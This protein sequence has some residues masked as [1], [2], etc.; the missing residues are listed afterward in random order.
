MSKIFNFNNVSTTGNSLEFFSDNDTFPRIGL[1]FGNSISRRGISSLKKSSKPNTKGHPGTGGQSVGRGVEPSI[2]FFRSI[3]NSFNPSLKSID[4]KKWNYGSDPN[5]IHPAGFTPPH[6][7]LKTKDGELSETWQPFKQFGVKEEHEIT[8]GNLPYTNPASGY[9][10]PRRLKERQELVGTIDLGT[11]NFTFGLNKNTEELTIEQKFDRISDSGFESYAGLQT[12]KDKLPLSSFTNTIL[13]NEDPTILGF[14]IEIDEV[15]SPLFNGAVDDFINKYG[16][17]QEIGGR[18]GIYSEFIAQFKKFFKTNASQE[19][20]DVVKNYYITKL[21]GLDKVGHVKSA[22]TSGDSGENL[23]TNFPTDKIEISIKE[24][25]EQNI[26]YLAY[27]YNLLSRSRIEGKRIIPK[28]LLRFNLRI[29]VTEIRN[30]N[31]VVKVGSDFQVLNDLI[32]KKEYNFYECEFFFNNLTHG[33]SIEI[34]GTSLTTVSDYSLS[35]NYKFVSSEFHKFV[36][37]PKTQ[38]FEPTIYNDELFDPTRILPLDTNRAIINTPPDE[39]KERGSDS[40]LYLSSISFLNSPVEST[41]VDIYPK[42]FRQASSSTDDVL[43]RLK[44]TTNKNEYLKNLG[45]NLVRDI[46]RA[47]ADAINREIGKRFALVN[48]AINERLNR[49][50]LSISLNTIQNPRNIYNPGNQL[51]NDLSNAI[52]GFVGRSVGRFFSSPVNT[53]EANNGYLP[54]RQG[55]P[56]RSSSIYRPTATTSISRISS[57]QIRGPRNIYVRR[58]FG[59]SVNFLGSQQI[60]NSNTSGSR[61]NPF[62]L[63]ITRT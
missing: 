34:G 4:Q 15:T 24:D 1:N 46:S 18:D 9:K 10:I 13:D 61:T 27:L 50:G 49:L 2:N 52:R 51:G 29:I 63:G 48:K 39:L 11:K 12:P 41:L 37:N 5:R 40:L 36:F 44:K 22:G 17:N 16:N 3:L 23:F 59:P 20:N 6:A 14:D 26:S 32:S 58:D 25:V 38:D 21:T 8:K 45:R 43:G 33:S 57:T 62:V 47:G 56:F 35:F 54:Q 30:Y 7:F 19:G 42:V 28:N 31:R 60:N 53:S 55:G